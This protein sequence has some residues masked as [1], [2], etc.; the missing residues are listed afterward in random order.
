MQPLGKGLLQRLLLNLCAHSVQRA[1]IVGH[2]VD[3]IRPEA[4]GSSGSAATT[5]QRLY[6]CQWNVIYGRPHPSEGILLSR[7]YQTIYQF[8]FHDILFYTDIS[9]V[10]VKVSPLLCHAVFLKF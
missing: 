3:M 4:D 8:A 5:S 6:G 1:D 9:I 2:L 7:N 10:I